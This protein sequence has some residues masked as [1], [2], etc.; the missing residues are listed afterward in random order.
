MV[1]FDVL[2]TD[3]FD[4]ESV[5]DQDFSISGCEKGQSL[6]RLA[7]M[8]SYGSRVLYFLKALCAILIACGTIKRHSSVSEA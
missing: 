7:S 8:I 3:R 6:M 5:V 1:G 4:P 2:H